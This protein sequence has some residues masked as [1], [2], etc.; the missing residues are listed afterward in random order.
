VR[1]SL[2]RV[3]QAESVLLAMIAG[4]TLAAAL[5]VAF[6]S[7]DGAGERRGS[8]QF[9]ALT[10]G[11]G[12]GSHTDLSRCPWLFDARLTD[13]HHPALESMSN[14]PD[15]CMWHAISIFPTPQSDPAE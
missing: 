6:D 8:Q 3:P 1:T 11:L 14:E 12:M 15:A 4:T 13:D 10:G 9:Q 5:L 2:N 7:I